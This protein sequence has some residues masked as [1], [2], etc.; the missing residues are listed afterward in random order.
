MYILKVI[1]LG[2]NKVLTFNLYPIPITFT[3][4]CLIFPLESKV[5]HLGKKRHINYSPWG[6]KGSNDA[7]IMLFFNY[8]LSFSFFSYVHTKNTKGMIYMIGR[9]IL[10]KNSRCINRGNFFLL[11]FLAKRVQSINCLDCVRNT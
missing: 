3:F 6:L 10:S 2:Q 7:S 8:H 9:Y 1:R 5:P 4:L 11:S